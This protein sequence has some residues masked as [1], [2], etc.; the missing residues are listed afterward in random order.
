VESQRRVDTARDHLSA[1]LGKSKALR[2]VYIG[3]GQSGG[4]LFMGCK[5]SGKIQ[6][7]YL[8]NLLFLMFFI[9]N[10]VNNFMFNSIIH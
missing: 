4:I 5:R 2:C 3:G 1:L 6:L 9:I 7:F 10:F 8:L